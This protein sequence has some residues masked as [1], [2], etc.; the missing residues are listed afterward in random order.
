[1]EDLFVPVVALMP[2][3]SVRLVQEGGL[4]RFCPD[5]DVLGVEGYSRHWSRSWGRG[6][7]S[8]RLVHQG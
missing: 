3:H 8:G 2:V 5:F 1:M 7:G 6:R 4:F